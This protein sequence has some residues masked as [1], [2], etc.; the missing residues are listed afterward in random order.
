MGEIRTPKKV[1]FILGVI[2]SKADLF[3]EVESE[4]K[5]NFG[6]ID[7]KTSLITFDFTDYYTKSMGTSLKRQFFSFDKLMLPDN[8]AETKIWSNKLEEKLAKKYSRPDIARPVNIDPGYVDA[9]KL[10]L[11]STKD[12]SHRIYLKKG[13]YAEITLRYQHGAFGFWEWTYPDYQ[14]AEY[15][16]FFTQ[17]RNKY[18]SQIK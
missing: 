7:F 9:A 3:P 18:L 1:K 15:L 6:P 11:A 14:S 5:K 17:A 2:S 12:Y 4:S 8:F 16:K 10:V 13:I